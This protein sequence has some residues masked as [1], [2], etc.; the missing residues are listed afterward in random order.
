M[1]REIVIQ[2]REGDHDAFARLAAASLGRLN[3]IARLILHDYAAA[4]DAVQEALVD[5]W[6]DLRSLRDPDRFDAWLTRILVRAART[7][8]GAV[9]VEG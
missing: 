2:A 3:A 5:A 8:V 1:D 4:E 7:R 6:R 9:S